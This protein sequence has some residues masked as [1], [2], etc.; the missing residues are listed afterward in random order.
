MTQ[1]LFC[2]ERHQ[3]VTSIY[4]DPNLNDEMLNKLNEFKDHDWRMAYGTNVNARMSQWRMHEDEDFQE[5][6]MKIY[7]WI[8]DLLS[9]TYD[10][11]PVNMFEL[12]ESWFAWYNEG[13]GT[14]IHDHRYCPFS[15]VYFINAPDESSSLYL[16]TS[17]IEFKPEPGRVIIF[18]G[19]V[20]HYV[21]TN[22][23]NGRIVLA[24]NIK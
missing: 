8:M 15:F 6:I 9:E 20:E 10:N 19:N 11:F 17:N 2:R 24:G 5:N 18:P 16:A 12:Y 21:P 1:R 22:K 13:D 23:S 4:P 3:I 14:R 7:D